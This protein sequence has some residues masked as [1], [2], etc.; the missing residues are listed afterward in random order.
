[1]LQ[2]G[3]VDLYFL[4]DTRRANGAKV[5]ACVAEVVEQRGLAYA[6]IPVHSENGPLTVTCDLQQPCEH[7]ALSLSAEKVPCRGDAD[8]LKSMLF[9]TRLGN[10]KGVEKMSGVRSSVART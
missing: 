1:L 3:V 10:D 8:H 6:R 9:R 7:I 2:G 5:G 4:L